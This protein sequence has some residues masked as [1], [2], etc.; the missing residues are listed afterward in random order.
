MT[1][2][3]AASGLAHCPK[4][5]PFGKSQGAVI[6]NKNGFLVAIGPTVVDKINSITIMVRFPEK[7]NAEQVWQLLLGARAMAVALEVPTIEEENLSAVKFENFW[8]KWAFNYTFTVPNAVHVA[9]VAQAIVDAVKNDVPS[10]SGRCEQ[11]RTNS[12]SEILLISNEIPCYVCAACI[13]KVQSV[14]AEAEQKYQ[15][16]EPDLVNGL[17]YGLGAA[18]LCGI[19][20]GVV[21]YLFNRIFFVLYVAILIGY[22]VGK[23]VIKGMQRTILPGYFAI[24]ILSV[25]SVIIGDFIYYNLQFL[26]QFP[27]TP[28]TGIAS[29]VT[30]IFIQVEMQNGLVPIGFSLLGAGYAIYQVARRPKFGVQ[31]FPLKPEGQADPMMMR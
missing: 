24:I 13:A 4:Q 1:E 10:Y 3:A 11:C 27:A 9:A 22:L 28:F 18:I 20:W 17:L 7:I 30:R 5:G 12:V 31:Y 6:G 16:L 29:F 25:I 15:S 23:A 21:T 2:L 14:E 19:G 8:L 26:H